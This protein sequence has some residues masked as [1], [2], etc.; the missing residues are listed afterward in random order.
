MMDETVGLFDFIRA[1]SETKNNVLTRENEKTYDC[2]MSSRS[3]SYYPDTIMYAAE[4][5]KYPAMTRHQ[6]FTYL[7]HTIRKRKRYT[8]W[9][10]KT[11]IADAKLVSG[12]FQM[13]E[14]KTAAA[15]KCMTPPEIECLRSLMNQGGP[16][17]GHKHE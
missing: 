5:N 17:K 6:H 7:F 2:F 11:K 10:K 1:L 3:F 8:K 14:R 9:G 4:L 13:S 16:I 12:A 15:L